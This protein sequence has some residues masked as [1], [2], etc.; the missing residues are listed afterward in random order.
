MN[1]GDALFAWTVFVGF[2]LWTGALTIAMTS[3]I[4][5]LRVENE[6]PVSYWII[7]LGALV[8]PI[9]WAAVTT[10]FQPDVWWSRENKNSP[11]DFMILLVLL[12][13]VCALPALVVVA[14]YR[15]RV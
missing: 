3:F 5:H 13:L 4:C 14:R 11:E 8:A 1:T 15:G 10:L 2:I 12:A 7:I 6:K 9:F